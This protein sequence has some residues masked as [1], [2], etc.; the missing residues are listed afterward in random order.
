M[1]RHFHYLFA[2]TIA[3][4]MVACGDD[5]VDTGDPE[6]VITTES[7]AAG[8]EGVDYEATVTASG[9]TGVDY[10]WTRVGG[11]LPAGVFLISEG[12]TTTLYG[13]PKTGG[14]FEFQLEVRDSENNAATRT[15]TIAIEA[16]PPQVEIV[17]EMLPIPAIGE[18]YEASIEAAN[19][20][21]YRWRVASGELPPGLVLSEDGTPAAT[22]SGTPEQLGRYSFTVRV[23]DALGNRATHQYSLEVV[24]ER[25]ELEVVDVRLPV[26]TVGVDYTFDLVGAGGTG[27]GYTWKVLDGGMLPPGLSLE[28]A[29]TPSA[30]ITGTPTQ[31]GDFPFRVE[32]R[33]DSGQ[34]ARRALYITV[35]AAPPPVRITTFELPLGRVGVDYSAEIRGIGGGGAGYMW[36]VE[37][38]TLP[39]GLEIV[40]GTPAMTL[41]GSP[42]MAGL[43]SFEIRLDGQITSA[44]QRYA[45]RIQAEISPLGFVSPSP[46]VLANAEGGQPYEAFIQATGGAPIPAT[47]PESEVRYNYVVTGGELPPGVSL[48]AAGEGATYRGRFD[49]IASALG[50]YTATVAVYDRLNNIATTV[51]QITV[52]PPSEPLVITTTQV[53]DLAANGCEKFELSA[54]GGGNSDF[55]WD[56]VSG[57][58]PP[59]FE[60]QAE[61]TPTTLVSGAFA[62]TPGSYPVTVRVTDSFGLT[63]TRA[64]TLEVTTDVVGDPRWGVMVGELDTDGQND[65]YVYDLCEETP[66][67]P[68]RVNTAGSL[69][70]VTYSSND[71]VIS[72]AGNAVAFIGDLEV[73]GR[74]DVY[75]V[76][77]SNGPTAASAQ[78]AYQ[79]AST[80]LEAYEIKWSPDGTK[81]GILT[82]HHTSSAYE[83]WMS[84]TSIPGAPTPAVQVSPNATSSSLDVYINN[85]AFS[86]D[87]S[88]L[89]YVGSFDGSSRYEIWVSD[90]SGAAPT[91]PVKI[92]ADP[93]NTSMDV[94]GNLLWAP[95]S[96]GIVFNADFG[97]YLRNELWF[98]NVSG[99]GPYT[100]TLISPTTATWSSPFDANSSGDYGRYHFEFN[101]QGTMLA[102]VGEGTVD[103]VD[104]TYVIDYAAGA[105]SNL[106]A[107]TRLTGISSGGADDFRWSPDGT[108]VLVRG[109]LRAQG[110]EELFILDVTGTLPLST[111]TPVRQ[112]TDANREQSFSWWDYTWSPDGSKVAFVADF[113][114]DGSE[115]AW[116]TDVS[117]PGS[118]TTY[119]LH[120]GTS[121]NAADVSSDIAF[122][123]DGNW[124]AFQGDLVSGYDSLYVTDVSTLPPSG[125]LGQSVARGPA[126]S[127]SLDITYNSTSW[128]DEWWW[129]GDGRIIFRGDFETDGKYEAAFLDVT[130]SISEWVPTYLFGAGQMTGPDQDI[131]YIA[132]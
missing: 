130:T 131:W 109:D 11:N 85:W 50:T 51:V 35:E 128:P 77:L 122:S 30:A 41:R 57:S 78:K 38:G 91:T 87:G 59:G 89:A 70:D 84:D 82:D 21:G 74:D 26:A 16:A 13:R 28:E 7:L 52:D 102:F 32:V 24:D 88:M 39:D 5:P 115:E 15:F 126:T 96:A 83:L 97:T 67:N 114:L 12:Q 56:I 64:L 25:P 60:L 1:H 20:D 45:V 43:Y 63:A 111:L 119:K 65:L 127:T 19:G 66:G 33:D 75:V 99:P 53:D 69:F 58:L 73:D 94:N 72:P 93:S 107:V 104:D 62:G 101:P 86:P 100:A 108:Q 95:D 14:T 80:T 6:L 118:Y 120:R 79:A 10:R 117:T 55:Q 105:F 90:V 49:G 22:L 8:N 37:S 98:S 47:A 110:T 121:S 129:V 124:V 31:V 9:G 17:T 46:I 36:S 76:D 4:S 106:Q 61:G 3:L 29:G 116:V 112:A 103:N 18:A 71:I 125:V 2:G 44:V 92:H 123:P 81:L 113:D 68:V 34:F 27:M 40:Q 23:E 132:R 54:Q 42:T 48:V